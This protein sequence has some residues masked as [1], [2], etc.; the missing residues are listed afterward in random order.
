MSFAVKKMDMNNCRKIVIKSFA[1]VGKNRIESHDTKKQQFETKTRAKNKCRKTTAELPQN[2]YFAV[3][4][5]CRKIM[6]QNPPPIRGGGVFCGINVFGY[7][8]QPA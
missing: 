2:S 4:E 1:E 3:L 7:F 5:K 8:F 6:P